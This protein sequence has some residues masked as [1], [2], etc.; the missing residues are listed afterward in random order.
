[1]RGIDRASR[2]KKDDV[3]D[4]IPGLYA[5]AESLVLLS[6]GLQ[7]VSRPCIT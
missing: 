2:T 7:L 4:N 3:K 5:L 1:M 6:R